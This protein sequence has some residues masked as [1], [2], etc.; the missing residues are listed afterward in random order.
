MLL[1]LPE[2]VISRILFVHLRCWKRLVLRFVCKRL[3]DLVKTADPNRMFYM[4]MKCRESAAKHNQPAL[5][6]WMLDRARK[7]LPEGKEGLLVHAAANSAIAAL[8]VIASYGLY[9]VDTCFPGTW[10]EVYCAPVKNSDFEVLGWLRLH[11]FLPSRTVLRV[12]ILYDKPDV[13]AWL[14]SSGIITDLEEVTMAIEKEEMCTRPT[15]PALLEWYRNEIIPLRLK[16]LT[17]K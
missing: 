12:V 2:I 5:L 11:G 16:A 13:M 7:R 6:R 10:T 3:N 15:G 1:E 4:A 17:L 14:I 9:D 8:E